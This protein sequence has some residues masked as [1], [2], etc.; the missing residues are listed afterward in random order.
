MSR[1]KLNRTRQLLDELD[2]C[3]TNPLYCKVC[4]NKL[5]GISALM[6]EDSYSK[7]ER[8]YAAPIWIEIENKIAQYN[9][10]CKEEITE[11]IFSNKSR[12]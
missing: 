12:A 3:L 6:M 10:R 7:S 2:Y 5:L 4:F 9:G 8:E 11:N 1:N